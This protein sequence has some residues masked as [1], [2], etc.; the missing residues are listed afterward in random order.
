[1]SDSISKVFALVLSLIGPPP[2]DTPKQL[3]LKGG[4]QIVAIGD[5][6]TQGGGYLRDIDAV[7]AKAYPELKLPRVINRGISGQKAED[8]VRRFDADVVRLNPAFVT[9][10][11]GINDVWHRLGAPHDAKVLAEY[12]KHVAT[13]VEHAQRA[14]IKVILLTP[15][16]IQE[17]PYSE[18]NKRLV[19]YVE[20]ERQIA[21]E[22]KCQFVDLH[23]FFLKALKQKPAAEQGNWLTGD[24][25]HMKPLGD[26]IMASGVLRA[27]GVPD[28]KISGEKPPH[29]SSTAL[30][31]R[32][33][34]LGTR[35]G[36]F[37]LTGDTVIV[38]DDASRETAKQLAA[39]LKPATT[40]T[41]PIQLE[42]NGSA[43]AIALAQD[44]GLADLGDEGYFLEASPRKIQLK[45][46][47]QAGLFYAVQTL[48]QLLPAQVYSRQGVGDVVWSIPCVKIKDFPRFGWRGLMLDSGHD[49]QNLPFVYKFIDAM[50]AHK[51]N[52]FHWHVTDLGTWSIEV[53]KYPKLLD[54]STRGRGV[55]PG[56]YTQEQIRQVV[57]YAADRHITVVPEIDMPGHS[58]PALLA[59]PELKCPLRGGQIWQYC[60]GNEKTYEFLEDVLSEVLDLFPSKFIHIGGDECPKDRWQQCPLCQAKMKAEHLQNEQELQ[61]Y[62]IKRIEKFLD[63]RGRRLIGWDEILEGGL[64]PKASVMSWR[65]ME[66]GITAAKSGHDVVMAPTSHLYFDYPQSADGFGKLDPGAANAPFTSLEKVYS[67]QPIPPELTA[68]QARHILGAQA[69]MWSDTHPTEANIE[70][71]VYPRACA[72]A[73][74]VWS[75]VATRD[76]TDFFG[77]MRVHERRL[78]ALN[79]HYRPLSTIASPRAR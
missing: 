43:T 27:L 4:D 40:W 44:A 20:A 35:S 17:D 12:K 54:S 65:G 39:Y 53:K 50:A 48:R 59:Y 70:W 8:L 9:I 28:E 21:A 62:F 2:A 41:I 78:A 57:Q 51:F 32:P 71:Q 10:S 66:G 14:G 74:V 58:V 47:T 63:S 16:L 36:H 6:I 31:P 61:S 46:P 24:G 34:S 37:T 45:A 69:Q 72:V 25:V 1:M 52:V 22:K 75:P 33:A 76:Y 38:T 15:T 68:Q 55:K 19:Q 3:Q 56:H 49:F 11:I 29:T 26:A 42:F 7:L 77:R 60:V 64:A 79:L 13:M 30:I 23:G 73:E 18:G 5:S 67:F